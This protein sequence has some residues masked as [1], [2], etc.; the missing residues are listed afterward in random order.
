MLLLFCS[1][2][3]LAG[4]FFSL[5]IKVLAARSV[6]TEEMMQVSFVFTDRNPDFVV[7]GET[8]TYS[9]ESITRAIR[10][11][12]AGSRFI[13]TNPDATGPSNDGILPATGSCS[14]VIRKGL[15]IDRIIMHLADGFNT[16]DYR[17]GEYY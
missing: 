3:S 13:V 9:F 10:L 4:M 6:I 1:F 8:R 16:W 7:I 15:A 11:I 12:D 17:H 5:N 2:D 14:V